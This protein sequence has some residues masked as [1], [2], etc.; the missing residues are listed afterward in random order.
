[1][2]AEL[3]LFGVFVNAGLV[4]ALVAGA[5]LIAV[6][7]ALTYFG[8]YRATWHPPLFDLALFVLLWGLVVIVQSILAPRL[9]LSLG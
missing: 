1:M 8:A 7:R 6:R 3:N 2:I 4:A 5:L 9:V